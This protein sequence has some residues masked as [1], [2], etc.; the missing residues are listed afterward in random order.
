MRRKRKFRKNKYNKKVA[1]DSLS[2]IPKQFNGYCSISAPQCFS[3]I[4]NESK[5]L[6]F[7]EKLARCHNKKKKVLVRLEGVTK[8]SADAIVVL[9]SNMVRFKSSNIDFNGTRPLNAEARNKLEKSGFFDY[10]YNDFKK[11]A[12]YVFNNLKSRIYTHG[13]KTVSS[14]LADDLIMNA[15][16]SLWDEQ[17]RCQ[18]AQKTLVEL[19]HNTYDHA[20]LQKGEKHWWLSVEHDRKNKEVIFSFIDFGMGIYESLENKSPDNPL[21]KAWNL[22]KKLNPLAKSQVELIRLILEGQLHR[23]QSG[24]YYRGKGLAKIYAL[25]KANKIS[26]LCIISNKAYI[27]VEKD[28]YHS[29]DNEFKG[30]FISFKIN[31][32]TVSLPWTI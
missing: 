31:T 23:S 25:N 19:M 15:S 11:Q 12:D 24:D 17:R 22:L 6:D 27:N 2:K 8:M 16:K 9:L 30:T 28:D 1:H 13:E 7:L 26:S 5:T 14:D 32:N 21:Y 4:E 10:L 29:I 18:G 3:L 20:S